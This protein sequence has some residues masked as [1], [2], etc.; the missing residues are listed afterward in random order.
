MNE[1]LF[2]LCDSAFPTGGFAHS[3]GLE[4]AAQRGW[5]NSADTFYAWADRFMRLSFASSDAAACAFAHRF[6]REG[7]TAA[8]R[9][10]NDSCRAF[11][12]GFEQREASEQ[13][14]RS[15]VAAAETILRAGSPND[16]F[17]G[18]FS[19]QDAVQFPVAWGLACAA[20]GVDAEDACRSLWINAL[21]QMAYCAIRV[22]PL[23]QTQALS[24]AFAVAKNTDGLCV[25]TA[26]SAQA[27]GSVFAPKSF[28]PH[29]DIAC[30]GHA[31][32]HAR[33]FKS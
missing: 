17:R 12:I 6:A 14:A 20:L 4:Y 26:R 16:I 7:N 11:R 13:Q 25:E 8:L 18:A 23:G 9:A 33:Y 22:V 1:E 21:K 27:A 24:A 29:A 30:L 19:P 28:F 31:G 5:V 10:L 2:F 3:Q 32:M 15:L